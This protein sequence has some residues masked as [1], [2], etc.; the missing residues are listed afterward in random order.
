MARNIMSTLQLCKQGV[1]GLNKVPTA[2]HMGELQS[3]QR[4]T[5]GW[6]CP[7]AQVYEETAVPVAAHIVDGCFSAAIAEFSSCHT[8]YGLRRL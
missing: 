7:V 1:V 5:A 4:A 3:G 2:V 6:P 8:D